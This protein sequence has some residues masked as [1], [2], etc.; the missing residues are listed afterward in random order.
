MVQSAGAGL[1]GIAT[2]STL[3][4]QAR[5][6]V[7]VPLTFERTNMQLHIFFRSILVLLAFITCG[8]TGRTLT[9]DD[10]IDFNRDI[11]PL[12]SDNCFS[13]H[14]PD[15]EARE[16]DLRLD[17]R[18]GLFGTAESP[19]PVQPGGVDQSELI[20][21]IS[22]DDPDERMPPPSSIKNLE[23]PQ[24]DL[25][26][27]WVSQGA[28]WEEHWAFRKPNR[29]ELPLVTRDDWDS[30]T[31]RLALRR[32]EQHGLQ[33][34]KQAETIVL[35]RRLYLDLVGLIPTPEQADEWKARLEP[36]SG[37]W[38]ESAYKELVESLVSSPLYGERWARR[39]LDLARYAD[40]N[41]YEKD[42][43]RSMW[44][45]R[46]W[47]VN[48]LNNDVTFDQFT[49]EQIAG[50][51]LPN[52]TLDQRVAT[53]FHRN[54]MLNE[55][56]GIDPL[57]FRFYAMTDRVATTGTVWLGL[58][59]GCAQCHT[60]KYDPITHR[61]Y[62][63]LMALMNNA[64]EPD[65]ALPSAGSE[66]K[67]QQNLKRAAQLVRELPSHW[68]L[69]SKP[70]GKD[71][72]DNETAKTKKVALAEVAFGNW[73]DE[74]HEQQPRWI[75]AR[76]K[77]ATS[78]L[79]H[80]EILDDASILTSG[81]SAKQDKF[82]IVLHPTS[83]NGGQIR[84]I[85]L[86]T[87]PHESLPAGGPGFTYYE[88]TKGDFFLGELQIWQDGQQMEVVDAT[89]TYSKNRFGSNPVNAQ[90]ALDGDPQT[91]WSVHG[92]QGERHVA[93]F[94]L[95][96]PLA[97]DKSFEVRMTFGR[98]FSSSFG[99]FRFSIADRNAVASPLTLDVLRLL[100][101]EKADLDEAERAV[102][103]EAFLLGAAPLTKFASTILD[104]R[105]PI[106][107]VSTLVLQ[108]RPRENPRP[109]FRHNRGEFL[110]PREEVS[111]DVPAVLPSLPA[112]VNAD[113][114]QL[115]RWLVSRQNP[116]TARV[117]VNRHWA[118]LFGR[119][120]VATVE[121][122]GLQGSPPTHPE[123]LDWLAV[124]FMEDGWSLKRL[125]KRLVTSTVYRQSSHVDE[126]GR[127][128]D[129]TNLWLSRA[130]RNR[131][132]AE[133]IR[134]A[135]LVAAGV[136]SEKM[137]GPSVR[138]LQPAGVTEAAWGKPKWIPS[139]GEDRYRR[140]IYTFSKRTAPFAMFNTF[141]AP[142]GELCMARRARSNSPLQGLTLLNDV[143][144]V[145]LCRAAGASIA[146][147][148]GTDHEKVGRLFRRVLTRHPESAE[149]AE[150]LRFVRDIRT[151]IAAE[152]LSSSDIVGAGTVVKRTEQERSEQAVWTLLARVLFNLDEAITRN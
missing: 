93:L 75:L 108:E 46:D 87:L 114:L 81:D 100:E 120:I 78:N 105:R 10:R 23:S 44:P 24:I 56:G 77:Q 149:I 151:R 69:K 138:P 99:R 88:G 71:S 9:A 86:E 131:L 59:I 147:I 61:E 128:L 39:W 21:R 84:A 67:Y 30:P 14:G 91:G 137:F 32:M 28:P 129:P 29:P 6:G 50:D 101:K 19:G 103:R 27:R 33:P 117:V 107:H 143:M 145:D 31:D 54:T 41:G 96:Q 26:K 125:H 53:G 18:E 135:T 98:H 79:P 104:L 73:L 64:D 35:I 150:M 42:R 34:S 115:A 110:Q 15:D 58:T 89:E 45:Y 62:Y 134:D 43:D 111:P 68:P 57:E 97:D 74:Q 4:Q 7:P 109:T 140:S 5:A 51:L 85:R 8:P 136:L 55:E 122:F 38:N 118:A 94:N 113:R 1:A 90:L 124:E 80:L 72:V 47:V 13:C 52:A 70:S 48:A 17:L 146:L 12:L 144:F 139:A 92:R 11:R 82:H 3:L 121:D 25:L 49:I 132:E 22:S 127:D 16:A 112:G 102:L 2:S 60:H 106:Q 141:G 40:T 83:I 37:E 65:L 116:L 152:T 20:R 130:S 119:G 133:I 148:D 36:A 95:A 123:L 63:Q 76:P 126:K 142:S 66:E